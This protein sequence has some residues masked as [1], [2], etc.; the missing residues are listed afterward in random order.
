MTTTQRA[1]PRNITAPAVLLLLALAAQ[2]PHA[3]AVFVR[4]APHGATWE[5]WLS[6]AGGLLYAIALEGATAFFV[7]QGHKRWAIAFAV[8]SVAHN[9]AYYMPAE[10]TVTVAGATLLLRNVVG[11]ILISI[12]LPLAIAAFSHVQAQGA[13]TAYAPASSASA[14][15]RRHA[16]RFWRKPEYEPAVPTETPTAAP[17]LA[18]TGI[19]TANTVSVARG[20]SSGQ[21]R[22]ENA[23]AKP[24]K[25]EAPEPA[26]L[27]PEQRRAHIAEQGLTDPATIAAQYGVK[28][29]TAQEDLRKVRE[30]TMHRNGVAQ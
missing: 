26:R 20:Q 11:S 24:G 7:W 1:Q 25:T 21:D 8:F 18:V 4:V 22:P 10:W 28:I 5:V 6:I 30:A 27:S 3:M 17:T 9:V 29:R 2:V 14:P 12:S 16:W 15:T 13:E 23:P 19:A